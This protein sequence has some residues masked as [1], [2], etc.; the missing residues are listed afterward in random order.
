MGQTAS[1]RPSTIEPAMRRT[2]AR[3]WPRPRAPGARPSWPTR[4]TGRPAA[5]LPRGCLTWGTF[6]SGDE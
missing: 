3:P 2:R 6:A 1:G 5:G 4:W